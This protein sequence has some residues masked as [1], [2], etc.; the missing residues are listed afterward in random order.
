MAETIQTEQAP[1]APEVPMT[2][3]GLD[4]LAKLMRRA[5][6]EL[7]VRLSRQ[8]VAFIAAAIIRQN[9]QLQVLHGLVDEYSKMAEAEELAALEPEDES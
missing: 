7:G 5:R 9:L 3:D 8:E 6:L 2:K 1:E 4:P